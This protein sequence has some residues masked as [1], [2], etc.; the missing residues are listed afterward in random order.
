GRRLGIPLPAFALVVAMIGVATGQAGTERVNALLAGF[1]LMPGES[2]TIT[3]T[4]PT[5]Q[6]AN[7]LGMLVTDTGVEVKADIDFAVKTDKVPLSDADQLL[8]AMLKGAGGSASAPNPTKR[9]PAMPTATPRRFRL[10][11]Q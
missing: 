6:P 11:R 3:I 4:N 8:A 1:L 5:N 10:H 9:P 7:P 2:I